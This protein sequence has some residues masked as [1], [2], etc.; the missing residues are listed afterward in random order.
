MEGHWVQVV[1]NI[2]VDRTFTY[3]SPNPVPIG[4][5]VQA[6]FH[7]RNLVGYVI[8]G[9]SEPLDETF[10]IKSIRK[11]LDTEPLFDG[12][13]LSL[14]RWM[15]DR[16]LCSLGE[17]LAA[18][19]P[20][21]KKEVEVPLFEDSGEEVSRTPPQLTEEQKRAV[22]QILKQEEGRFYL[23]GITG[24]GKTE[25]FLRIAEATLAQERG[26]IYLVP[27]IALTGQVV[28]AIEGRFGSRAAILHSRLTPSQRL[29]EWRKILRGEVSLIVGARSAVF[30]P[31]PNLG[32]IILDEE[33]EGSYKSSNT[34]RYHARQVAM[35]R[36]NISK[37]RLVMGSATPS[38]EA[39]Y[40]MQTG[41]IQGI[42]LLKRLAGGRLPEVEIVD[43]SGKE[44]IFSAR[45]QEEILA[46]HKT[47]K[48]TILFL[49]RRGFSYSF[50][51]NTCGFE[52]KCRHCSVNLT[53][54]KHRNRMICH[55]CGYSIRPMDIC[56][57]CG[58]LDVG[59]YG[60]GTEKIEEEAKRIFPELRIARVDTDAVERKG[61]LERILSEFRRGNIDLLLGTQMVAKGLNFPGVRLVGIVLADTGL[62]LPDFRAAERTFSLIVQVSGRAGRFAADGKV[63]VQ[64]FVPNHMAVQCASRL[65]MDEFYQQEIEARKALQ[66][67][68][69]TRL[70]RLVFRS[71]SS[72]QALEGATTFSISLRQGIQTEGEVLGP[73]ECPIGV[74]AGNYRYQIL[75]RTKAFAVVHSVIKKTLTQYKP[76]RGVYLE[77]D[78]DPVS[79]L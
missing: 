8:N 55:Y 13:Y 24:S 41:E 16:Y 53:F 9:G 70:I 14:A 34:P 18:M 3:T 21:G 23:F 38:V 44:G 62:H 17:A 27:E 15:A 61:T 46:T 66:F 47:G 40:L 73:A 6:P 19:L 36:C 49:N 1:F 71:R 79:L 57:A 30:A 12:D 69:F 58:S 78:L 2:P 11:I 67:P 37:A 59:Y 63:I 77:V 42:R 65:A 68:P 31:H 32:L 48:Q 35:R 28:E 60:A 75:I 25:V 51:C 43:L 7:G 4:V 50:H 33:H 26:V 10:E 76:C 56:P 64:T 74:I 39:Y 20:G 72:E 45:L 29:S 52:M 22:E 54:H 5:R